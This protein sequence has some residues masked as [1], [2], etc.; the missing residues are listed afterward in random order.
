MD[1]F[2]RAGAAGGI[3]PV[4]AL[5]RYVELLDPD[6]PAMIVYTSGTTGKPKGQCCR[7]ETP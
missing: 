1:G 2:Y 5:G 4:D 6:E 3:N 7:D